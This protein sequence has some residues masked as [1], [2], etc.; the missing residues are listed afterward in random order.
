MSGSHDWL[1]LEG[2]TVLVAGVANRRSV[3]WHVGQALREVGARAAWSVRT[4][5]RREELAKKLG[6]DPVF[7]CDV[8]DQEQIDA[9][10]R[11]V[12]RELGQVHG[13][14]H[15][16]AHA[17]Y[18]EGWK[19]FDETPRHVFLGALD[20]SCFSLVAL[21]NALR[22]SFAPDASVVTISIS[23]TSMAAENYGVMAPVKAALD[24]TVVFLAK[25]FSREPRVRFNGVPGIGLGVV[26]QSKKG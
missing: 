18:S 26:K 25:S 17:D 15:S 2:K 22:P 12:Q 21:S 23:T 8:R 6:D 16:M 9:L 13:F 19:S 24:S 14:V 11:D 3:G 5:E 20:V 10:G 4:E 1:G 7:V